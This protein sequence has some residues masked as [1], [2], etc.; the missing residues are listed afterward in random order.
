MPLDFTKATPEKVHMETPKIE[1]LTWTGSGCC[2]G[3]SG[4]NCHVDAWFQSDSDE[5][6]ESQ[7]LELRT[8]GSGALT[9]PEL[10][11]DEYLNG[12]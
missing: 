1:G 8:V 5:D 3:C 11:G 10:Q 6:N 4:I 9:W 7:P 2:Y 12:E